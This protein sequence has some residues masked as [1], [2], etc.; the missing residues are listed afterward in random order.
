VLLADEPTGALDSHSGDALFD[1][2]AELQA[3]RGL[4]PMVVTHDPRVARRA[5]R[6]VNTL[7]GRI[8]AESVKAIGAPPR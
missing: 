8:R 3:E 6:V 2:L 5:Q 4:T 7:D 1:W